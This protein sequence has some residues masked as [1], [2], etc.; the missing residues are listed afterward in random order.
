MSIG[1]WTYGLGS[2]NCFF[3]F[4]EFGLSDF[5]ILPFNHSFIRPGVHI[6]LSVYFWIVSKLNVCYIVLVYNSICLF[7]QHN[8]KGILLSL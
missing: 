8:Q 7:G 5:F 1:V 3:N 2:Q 6:K 4:L